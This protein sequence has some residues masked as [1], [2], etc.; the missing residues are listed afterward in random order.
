MLERKVAMQDQAQRNMAMFSDAMRMFNPFN[1]N[2]AGG[3]GQP[4]SQAP[5]QKPAAETAAKDDIRALKE[6]LAA[7]Q[8]KLDTI[9]DK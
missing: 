1:A 9:S 5:G 3:P 4:P 7:M 6:Q 2:M 8:K